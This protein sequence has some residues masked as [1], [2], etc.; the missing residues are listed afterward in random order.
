MKMKYDV[1]FQPLGV[2][3]PFPTLRNA[4]GVSYKGAFISLFCLK[5]HV[6]FFKFYP[7]K[8]KIYMSQISKNIIA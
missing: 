6:F 2:R 8:K 3:E 5:G 1:S 4:S 7:A